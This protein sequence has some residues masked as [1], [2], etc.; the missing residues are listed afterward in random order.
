MTRTLLTGLA[1]LA[2]LAACNNTSELGD[3]IHRQSRERWAQAGPPSYTIEVVRSCACAGPLVAIT[4]EVRNKA[5]VSWK[6]PD[7]TPLESQYQSAYLDVEGLFQ[8]IELTRTQN[9]F[10]W[11]AEYHPTYGYPAA[12]SINYNPATTADDLFYT[13]T[14]LTPLN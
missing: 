6:Y 14:N 7:G 9:V 11:G 8:L 13:A 10:S 3:E 12:I 4:I 1:A 2:L 5:I